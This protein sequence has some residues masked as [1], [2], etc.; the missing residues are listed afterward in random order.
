MHK[1]SVKA[2]CEQTIAGTFAAFAGKVDPTSDA[3]TRVRH[4]AQTGLE[5]GGDDGHF[6]TVPQQFTILHLFVHGKTFYLQPVF[7]QNPKHLTS[8]FL[9]IFQ[10]LMIFFADDHQPPLFVFSKYFSMSL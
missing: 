5:Y 3:S 2:M 10:T 7:S 6:C 1:L 8:S 9:S 4:D